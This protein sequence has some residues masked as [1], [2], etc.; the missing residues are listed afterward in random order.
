MANV[1]MWNV[2]DMR[3]GF[4]GIYLCSMCEFWISVVEFE[5]ERR[6]EKFEKYALMQD[7]ENVTEISN[8]KSKKKKDV[9]EE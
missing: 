9:F 5:E 2:E 4:Y 6:Y 3:E 8:H 1:M 7:T